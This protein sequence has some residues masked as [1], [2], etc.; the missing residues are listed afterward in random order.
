M[1]THERGATR[2]IRRIGG[3]RHADLRRD[4]D[5]FLR[6]NPETMLQIEESIRELTGGKGIAVTIEE[7]RT[8]LG[9][10]EYGHP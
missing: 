6:S 2:T 7:L 4:D 1:G 10:T 3:I 5:T 9:L 8:R